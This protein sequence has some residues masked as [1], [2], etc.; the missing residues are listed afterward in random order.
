MAEESKRLVELNNFIWSPPDN[1]DD[2][3]VCEMC[4]NCLLLY[5]VVRPNGI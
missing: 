2:D 4:I 1:E 3:Q 5:H